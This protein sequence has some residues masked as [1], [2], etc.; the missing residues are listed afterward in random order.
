HRRT[1][2]HRRAVLADED[3]LHRGTRAEHPHARSPEPHALAGHRGPAPGSDA[4]AGR[5]PVQPSVPIRAGPVPGGG[6]AAGG[7]RGAGTR[8]RLLVPGRHTA[9][10]RI[11]ASGRG[12]VM[13]CT[14]SASLR[15]KEDALLRV[16]DLVVEYPVGRT[17]V[18]VSAVSGISFDLLPGETL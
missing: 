9:G 6:A 3:A 7:G 16:E 5:V 1:R 2:P 15:S 14:G 10:H 17:G 18:K 8:V 11:A 13:A 12:V 4:S